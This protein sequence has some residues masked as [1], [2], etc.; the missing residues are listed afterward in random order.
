MRPDM[1]PPASR[2]QYTRR[3][4]CRLKNAE[5]NLLRTQE[6]LRAKEERLRAIFDQ[7]AVGIAVSTLDGRLVEP[8][9]KCA[10]ILG[11]TIEELQQRTFLDLTHPDD[12]GESRRTME[13]LLDRSVAAVSFEKRYVRKD[14]SDV[15]RGET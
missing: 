3:E 6:E 11:Y 14:G 13:Q 12:L 2:R 9:Q 15:W 10:E 7:A 8:N 5:Q 1:A 4:G